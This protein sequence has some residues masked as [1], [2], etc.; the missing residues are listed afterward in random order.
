[1]KMKQQLHDKVKEFIKIVT[2]FQINKQFIVN[3]KHKKMQ[4]RLSSD[5]IKPA[6]RKIKD[7]TCEKQ[8]KRK[9]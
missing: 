1:L 5:Y 9:E 7:N 2:D 4:R 6:E 3:T 8:F